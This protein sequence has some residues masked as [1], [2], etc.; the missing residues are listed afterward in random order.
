MPWN[1]GRLT[2]RPPPLRVLATL[3]D[4]TAAVIQQVP[5]QIPPL[6]TAIVR[7]SESLSSWALSPASSS[8]GVRTT[9]RASRTLERASSRVWAAPGLL[10]TYHAER[11][12]VGRSVLRASGGLLRAAMLQPRFL[13][14]IR[15]LLAGLATRIDPI[16]RTLAGRV[17]GIDIRYPTSAGAHPLAGKRAPDMALHPDGSPGQ[18]YQALHRGTLVLL[19]PDTD[20]GTAA[21]VKRWGIPLTV[22]PGTGP[23]TTLVRPDG[24]VAWASDEA[25]PDARNT[26]LHAA[27]AHWYDE[28]ATAT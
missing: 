10:D 18:L 22:L 26:A 13:R 27:L 25:D 4:E 7:V 16:N 9:W 5:L 3:A 1:G 8:S 28:P 12:P 6:H 23:T 11:H 24:Y 2:C 15:N 17:S 21:V 14:A 19:T 20:T